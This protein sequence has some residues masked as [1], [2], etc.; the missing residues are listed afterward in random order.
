MGVSRRL[1]TYRRSMSKSMPAPVIF[2]GMRP[3]RMVW[4]I[5]AICSRVT[6]NVAR[7]AQDGQHSPP[8]AMSMRPPSLTSSGVRQCAQR[9]K[10]GR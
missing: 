4:L 10:R 1:S 8:A 7:E 3:W 6:G 2:C 9:L 5:Q